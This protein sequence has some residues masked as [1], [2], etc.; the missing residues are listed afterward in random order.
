MKKLANKG[1]TLIELIVVIVIIGILAA[2]AVPKFL[3]LSDSAEAAACKQN[4]AAIKSAG[5]ISYANS[6]IGGAAQYPA[7][8]SDMV[9]NGY[10]QDN[11]V[12]PGG[13]SYTWVQSDGDVSC[14]MSDHAL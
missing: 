13:G 11:P 5:S 2:V 7:S 14:S 8:I 4:Q 10:L 1:F 6:A 9:T 3:D 12:C